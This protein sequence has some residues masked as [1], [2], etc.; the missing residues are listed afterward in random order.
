M[1]ALSIDFGQLLVDAHQG[2]IQP[3]RKIYGNKPSNVFSQF[4]IF[5]V[6][7]PSIFEQINGVLA[8]SYLFD[9]GLRFYIGTCSFPP[10]ALV[11]KNNVHRVKCFFILKIPMKP[12]MT[13]CQHYFGTGQKKEMCEW[14]GFQ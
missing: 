2:C 8:S 1:S 13:E 10:L 3:D 4:V 9:S 14:F 12:A 7:L 11:A 6:S 5:P